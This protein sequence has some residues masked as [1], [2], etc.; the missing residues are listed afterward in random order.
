M[1]GKKCAHKSLFLDVVPRPVGWF[2]ELSPF[3]D[4]PD[5]HSNGSS[6]DLTRYAIHMWSEAEAKPRVE[7]GV[8]VSAVLVRIGARLQT[9]KFTIIIV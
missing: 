6:S 3:V 7:D 8:F 4:P 1:V 2:R 9:M 5:F